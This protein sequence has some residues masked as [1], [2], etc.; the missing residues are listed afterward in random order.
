MLLDVLRK[1]TDFTV[2]S[3]LPFCVV[4]PA[5]RSPHDRPE[6]EFLLFRPQYPSPWSYRN[7][8]RSSHWWAPSAC[9]SWAWSCLASSNWWPSGTNRAW[10]W[11]TGACGRTC[12]SWCL[13]RWVWLPVSTAVSAISS[14]SSANR[15]ANRRRP[16]P[17]SFKH[18]KYHKK[19]KI[20]NTK[21][22]YSYKCWNFDVR[23]P[24]PIPPAPSIVNRQG[25]WQCNGS[26]TYFT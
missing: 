2:N 15:T 19:K 14:T 25:P 6:F 3:P 20:Q 18:K 24:I 1:R 17:T 23:Q 8:A 11:D 7:W 12:R 9:H 13:A 26:M 4:C 21:Y 22:I 10:V 5:P 16:H